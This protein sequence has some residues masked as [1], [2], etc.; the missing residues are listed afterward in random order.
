MPGDVG[1]M[2]HSPSTG[3]MNLVDCEHL[4]NFDSVCEY[5][6]AHVM[7]VSARFVEFLM[8]DRQVQQSVRDM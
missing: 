2:L 3:L 1:E 5:L 8:Y 6:S 7:E 4:D